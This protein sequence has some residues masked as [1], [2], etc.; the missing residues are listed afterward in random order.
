MRKSIQIYHPDQIAVAA[1][2]GFTEISYAL[3]AERLAYREDCL[4]RAAEIR[5]MLDAHHIAC[6]QTHLP[7]YHLLISSEKREDD[8]EAAIHRAIRASAIL[9]ASWAAIH[10]RTAVNDGYNRTKSFEDNRRDLTSYL[11]TAEAV[12]V[13]LA[14]ENMPLYPFTQPEWRFFGGG[15][16]ELIA[17]VDSF[18]SAHIGICWDFGHAHTAALNQSAALREVGGRLKI[19]HV[20]DN[21]RNGDHHQMPLLASV[22]WHSIDWKQIMPVLGEIGYEGPMTLELI[23]PP[24][25]MQPSFMKLGHDALTAL[26]AMM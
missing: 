23:Q 17:L 11:E 6:T 7:D 20:H 25:P 19:T 3:G 5:A 16:E 18:S 24:A 9:G 13:G 14:V 12:G 1:A 4:A 8:T 21:Y 15:Y 10:P 22:E 26:E 2:A